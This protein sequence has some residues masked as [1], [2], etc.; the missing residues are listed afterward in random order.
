[1]T[2]APASSAARRTSCTRCGRPVLRQLVGRVAALDVTAD[3]EPLPA[4]RAAALRTDH[5]LDWCLRTTKHGPDMRWADCHRRS[6]PCG[7]EHVID[8]ACAA[9]PRPLVTRSRRSMPAPT[10]QLA[11]L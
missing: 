4:A 3:A 5:R 11:L 10:G 8:H 9:P 7:H 1:M 2:R 6:P